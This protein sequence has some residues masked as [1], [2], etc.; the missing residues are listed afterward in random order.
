MR[1]YEYGPRKHNKRRVI[2]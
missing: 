2:A 1:L